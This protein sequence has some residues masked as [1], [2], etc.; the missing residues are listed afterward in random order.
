G[1]GRKEVSESIK[2]LGGA[3]ARIAS[4]RR[5]GIL[6]VERI[7][8]IEQGAYEALR[9][10]EARLS[11][12]DRAEWMKAQRAGSPLGAEDL[13]YELVGSTAVIRFSGI[14]TKRLSFWSWL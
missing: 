9:D 5:A 1:A 2:D 7:A 11:D 10:R 14:V 3:V 12:A 8:A 13:G 6:N 4:R